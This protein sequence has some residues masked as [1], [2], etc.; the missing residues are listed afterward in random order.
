MAGIDDSEMT[1]AEL[2]KKLKDPTFN[3]QIGEA[4]LQMLIDKYGGLEL[5]LA[6]YNAGPT[7]V[8]KL[9]KSE[10]ES[11]ADIKDSLPAETRAYVPKVRSIFEKV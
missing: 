4:Y 8:D 1:N 2:S 3:K 5:A 9:R 7:L 6:A 11:Y 10:G